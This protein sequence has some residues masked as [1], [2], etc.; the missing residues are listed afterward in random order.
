MC[1]F[2][3]FKYIYFVFYILLCD[4]GA[5][6]KN[7]ALTPLVS[8]AL[9]PGY[10]GG[11]APPSPQPVLTWLTMRR[12]TATPGSEGWLPARG[13]PPSS[14]SPQ[15]PVL[16][17]RWRIRAALSLTWWFNSA[18]EEGRGHAEQ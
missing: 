9:P 12:K 16:S 8:G 14:P 17:M 10:K 11:P 2:F 4:E 3:F 7:R 13:T 15:S 18:R 6:E 1:N 5:P